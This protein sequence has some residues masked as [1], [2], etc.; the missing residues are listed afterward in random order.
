M[1][2]S[3]LV[4][5][6]SEFVDQFAAALTWTARSRLV[7]RANSAASG[8]KAPS[9]GFLRRRLER[10]VFACGARRPR[11]S[12]CPV[13]VSRTTT[14]IGKMSSTVRSNSPASVTSGGSAREQRLG[15]RRGG[16]LAEH[17]DVQGAAAADVLDPA[18]HLCRAAAGVRAAQV[19]VAFLGRGE[20]R[21]RTPGSASASRTRARCRR[22]VR[23]PGRAP[24][25]SRRRPCAA[26]RCRRSSTAFA[27]TTSWLC[28]VAWRTSEPATRTFSITAN[29]VTRPVRPTLTTMSRSLVLTCSG[30]YL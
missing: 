14:S 16:D 28:S 26:R 19:D 13:S 18:A 21:C 2:H 30:G 1:R 17:L 27:F 7:R 20:R 29:G 5:A 6:V 3:G 25:G 15:Q 4:F 12:A 8:S 23:R 11:V 22:A 24:P 10:S 9:C